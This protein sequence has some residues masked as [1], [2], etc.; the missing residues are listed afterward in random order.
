MGIGVKTINMYTF[1]GCSSLTD[2]Q[3]GN[4]V[5]TINNYAFVDC[6]SLPMIRIPQS[7][8]SIGN[9]VFSG[10]TGLK[11]MIM[12]DKESELKLGSNGSSALF[13]SCPLDSVYIGRNITYST[14]SSDGYSPFYRNTS[15]RSHHHGQRNGGFE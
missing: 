9:S 2:L 6:S 11:T 7:V 15:L 13:S 12:E 4:S 1:S 14:S 10:C 8:N 5:A 3:I